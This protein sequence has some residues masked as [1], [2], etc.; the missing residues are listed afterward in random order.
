MKKT[1]LIEVADFYEI[2]LA[3]RSLI[4][5]FAEKDHTLQERIMKKIIVALLAVFSIN[6]ADGQS[7][8]QQGTGVEELVPKGVS[9]YEVMGDMN[10]DGI[11]DMA[12]MI[13]VDKPVFAIYWGTADGKLKLW[14]EY[15]RLLPANEDEDCTNNYTFEINSRG[16]L[17]ITMQP[18]CSQG[19]YT[20]EIS[21][22]SYR[23][24]NGDFFLIGQ[25][26]E[27]VQ[28]NTGE[29]EL[30]SENYLTWKRQVKTSNVF[31]DATPTEKWTRLTRKPLEKLVD[32]SLGGV[33]VDKHTEAYI[34]ERMD[35]IYSRYKDENVVQGEFGREIKR[36]VDYDG[37][38]CSSR[39]KKL[40]DAASDIC[41]K[42]D[43]ILMDYD[44][45]TCSQDDGD[46]RVKSIKVENITDSTA[47]AIV[48][49]TNYGQ[50]TLVR[51][52]LF[53]EKDE[54]YVDDFLDEGGE[55]EKAYFRK[56]IGAAR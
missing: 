30:V 51:L 6:C 15:S 47:L 22:Y 38:F 16:V 54:W 24:Q 27:S 17:N 3:I 10:K 32:C 21:R 13:N 7:L 49:A 19:S 39:Y 8:K 31:S 20:T 44:H 43:D 14:K 1:R 25:E 40:F 42:K 55:G 5:T 29:A 33:S 48:E 56:I 37:M 45:W 50:K 53:F 4:R 34:L 12:L 46:F 36:G 52:S 9:H 11:A 23:F 26:N 2:N 41:A 28:R 18:E 35:S